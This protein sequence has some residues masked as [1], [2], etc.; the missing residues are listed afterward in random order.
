MSEDQLSA[1]T[2][3]RISLLFIMHGYFLLVLRVY[4]K[5]V[6]IMVGQTCMFSVNLTNDVPTFTF[7][8]YLFFVCYVSLCHG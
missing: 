5:D 1:N 4:I 2:R 7:M 8:F 3:R 6:M